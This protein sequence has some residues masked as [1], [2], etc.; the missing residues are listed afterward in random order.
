MTALQSLLSHPNFLN[1]ET[2]FKLGSNRIFA[3]LS[4]SDPLARASA[5]RPRPDF[6][7][8]AAFYHLNLLQQLRPNETA[9]VEAE[10]KELRRARVSP[11]PRLT[12]QIPAG[13]LDD[14]EAT[15]VD[16]WLLGSEGVRKVSLCTNEMADVSAEPAEPK[17]LV[18]G[19]LARASFFYGIAG[20]F[21]LLLEAGRVIERL[22]R[23]G[24]R[25]DTRA[26][27]VHLNDRFGLN[28]ERYSFLA[29]LE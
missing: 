11:L 26:D 12:A 24:L 4:E 15:L 21:R 6:D 10:L 20:Y 14:L 13:A 22:S 19:N 1:K 8:L 3:L 7:N 9:E 5:P 27:M 23:H 2:Y 16:L 28:P 18:A 17:V 29:A 25:H